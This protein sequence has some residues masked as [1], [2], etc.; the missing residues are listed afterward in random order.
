MKRLI[1]VILILLLTATAL[2]GISCKRLPKEVTPVSIGIPTEDERFGINRS[3]WDMMFYNGKLYVGNGDYDDNAGPINIWCFNPA[4]QEW[5]NTGTVLDECVSRF[6][7]IDGKLTTV[8]TDPMED[9]SMG[10]YY[11]LDG[12]EWKTVRTIPGAVHNFDMVEYNGK[13]FSAIGVEP[14]GYPVAISEDGGATFTQVTFYKDGRVL[15][16]SGYTSIRVYKIFLFKGQIYA[17][18]IGRDASTSYYDLY[19]YVDGVFD[20]QKSLYDEI[21]HMTVNTSVYSSAIEYKDKYFIATG[22][23][24]VT[25][26]MKD[27]E[28][29]KYPN[30]DIIYDFIVKN[31]KLYSLTCYKTSDGRYKISVWENSSGESKDFDMLFYFYYDT[32]CVSFEYDSGSFY[33]GMGSILAAYASNGEIL[34]V[35]YQ[36]D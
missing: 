28:Y 4:T 8:G 19:K 10:N 26:D 16:T 36:L 22:Y 9:W 7:V 31:N 34:R 13:I 23:M 21:G 1:K 6:M 24:F 18:L 33:I 29:I 3:P 20:Y 11:V 17:A 32:P 25:E 35:E 15:N 5:K 30:S 12:G 2:L 14:G 27:F